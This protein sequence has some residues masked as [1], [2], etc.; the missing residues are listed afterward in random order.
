MIERCG[1]QL[2]AILLILLSN[3]ARDLEVIRSPLF[4]FHIP[5]SWALVDKYLSCLVQTREIYMVYRA[6]RSREQGPTEPGN[7]GP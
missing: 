4:F 1:I 5:M 7:A 3:L 6:R 2:V